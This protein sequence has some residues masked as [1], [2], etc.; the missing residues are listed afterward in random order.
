MH[1]YYKLVKMENTGFPDWPCVDGRED[2]GRCPKCKEDMD[3]FY[4]DDEQEG[5]LCWKC[6]M[7]WLR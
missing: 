5:Y 4:S 7:V 6:E 3:H 1:D 2:F